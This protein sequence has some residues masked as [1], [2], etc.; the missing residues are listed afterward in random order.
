M[1]IKTIKF[2]KIKPPF[3]V[4]LLAENCANWA[5][6]D[7]GFVKRSV[8]HNTFWEIELK[9][10][11]SNYNISTNE[12]VCNFLLLDL[13]TVKLHQLVHEKTFTIELLLEAWM[14]TKLKLV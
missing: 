5:I 4:N 6:A 1:E 12:T 10:L 2:Y 13:K 14:S 11:F 8:I 3:N 9:K 7:K